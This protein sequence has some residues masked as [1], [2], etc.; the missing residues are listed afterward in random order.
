MEADQ[1]SRTAEFMALFRALES[2]R[3]PAGQRLFNDPL[4]R[5]FLAPPL[6]LVVQLS[7]APLV[8]AALPW[9]IDHR[10]PGARS[11]AVARTRLIDDALDSAVRA[12]VGQVV[13]LGAG[14]DCRAYRLPGLQHTRVFEV[15]HPATSAAKQQRLRRL[16]G[17]L[18]PHVTFVGIDF[19]RQTLAEV[20]AGAGYDPSARTFFVWEGVT[21]YL[22]AE[23][24]DATLRYVCTH[25]AAGSRIMFT[26]VHRGVL[27]GSTP[28]AGTEHLMVT[29]AR[30]GEPW[31]F[32]LDPR[33]LPAYL[34]E[35]GLQLIEDVG[36]AEYRARY[37]G[38]SAQ[39]QRGYEFYRAA[40]AEVRG[41]RG[42][43]A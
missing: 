20:M 38:R 9:F 16:L 31:T 10:W 11:S 14:F 29:L 42:A 4:A 7:R 18:P 3:R 24:V 39:R 27:D 34:G 25:A 6:R 35:R 43:A 13:I 30:A 19:N 21:N 37:L 26:Y 36:A 12:G 40:L 41:D 22:T 5:G 17:A 8:G 33:A 2:V 15:D 1:A 32:G 23:A 28:F